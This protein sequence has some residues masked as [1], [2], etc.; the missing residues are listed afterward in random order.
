VIFA[1]AFQGALKLFTV[2]YSLQVCLLV[3]MQMRRSIRKP[4]LFPRLL[5]HRKAFQLGAFLGGFSG[6][7]KATIFLGI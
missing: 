1:F 3:L 7:Y 6:V 5:I 2:G 4:S